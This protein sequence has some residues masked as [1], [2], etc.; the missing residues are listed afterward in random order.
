MEDFSGGGLSGRP[1]GILAC[2]SS[3]GGHGI[4]PGFI[5]CIRQQLYPSP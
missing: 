3:R 4:W 2:E 5:S 1:Y